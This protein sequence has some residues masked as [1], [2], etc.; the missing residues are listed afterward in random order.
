MVVV[1]PAAV[2]AD[3]Y[4][5][6]AWAPNC[7]ALEVFERIAADLAVGLARGGTTLN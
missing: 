1:D 6:R 2:D 5:V 3:Y 7:L 4:H